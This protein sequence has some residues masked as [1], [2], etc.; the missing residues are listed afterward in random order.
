M[1]AIEVDRA[2]M[3]G[4]SMGG[5]VA[6]RPAIQYPENVSGLILAGTNPGGRE[7]VLGT[8][9]AQRIDSTPNPSDSDILHE[10]YPA[11]RQAEGGRFP[12]AWS[13]PA[14]ARR[15]RTIDVPA[16][17]TD[18]QV[19]AEDPW[20]RS[21]RNFREL[22]SLDTP[23]LAAAGR[24][25]PVTPPVNLRG[26]AAQIPDSE[27]HVFPGAHEFLFQS[28]T[29]FTQRW[30]ASSSGDDRVMRRGSHPRARTAVT[31]V[32]TSAR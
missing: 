2:D 16:S 6:Q 24:Q 26:I 8:R 18:A 27:P 21:N 30:M 5:F 29:A 3:L 28:R 9:Q 7:T 4:W 12:G 19:A 14:K 10:L 32:R 11:G 17:T 13:P 15:F 20:L 31:P 22:R 1:D 25:D 23:T